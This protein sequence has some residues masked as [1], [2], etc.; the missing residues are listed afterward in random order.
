[1]DIVVARQPIYNAKNGLFAYELLYRATGEATE[2][3]TT[4]PVDQMSATVIARSLLDFGIERVTGEMR[5]FVNFSRDLLLGGYWELFGREKV[6][7]ELLETIEP[8]PPVLEACRALVAA[9]YTL[10]L[11]DYEHTPDKDPLLRLAHLV[12][13][14]VLNRSAAE[15]EAN[16]EA[17]RAFKVPLLAERVE[18]ASMHELCLKLGFSYF[19]GYHYAKPQIIVG[20]GVAPDHVAILRLI[21][22]VRDLETSDAALEEAIRSDVAL[23][24]KLLRIVNSAAVGGRGVDSIRYAVG[25]VGRAALMR[26]LGLLL[27]AELGRSSAT[28]R[29]L[30][31]TALA[32]ARV[33][34]RLARGVYPP[35]AAG[36]LFITGLF[37]AID[38][39]MGKPMEEILEEVDLAPEVVQA[40]LSR[41]GPYAAP[42]RMM[43]SYER[44][45]WDPAVTEAAYLG[46]AAGVLSK[47][48]VDSLAWARDQL[49]AARS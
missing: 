23:T 33:C 18:D 17:P 28:N 38:R 19:Q 31:E 8:D 25:L 1:M 6:V 12:K 5:A 22:L 10:A 20:R 26:W 24:F 14:D 37:S 7:I 4:S 41:E 45:E 36:P 11:D 39:L 29:E 13:V 34:E 43:E 46:L 3:G 47:I 49:N 35:S 21:S 42:L 2:A 9:G 44:G 16:I 30:S 15:I 48:Y 27:F 40:L 32:R